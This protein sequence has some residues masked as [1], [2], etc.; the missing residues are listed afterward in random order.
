M[1]T[2]KMGRACEEEGCGV[3]SGGGGLWCGA[4]DRKT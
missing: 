2:A 3:E 1:L 4:D